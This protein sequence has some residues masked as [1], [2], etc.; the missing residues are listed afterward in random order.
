MAGFGD[1]KDI[2][3]VK[4]SIP[5]TF[6]GFFPKMME[7]KDPRIGSA[8]PGLLEKRP[9]NKSNSSIL[10]HINTLILSVNFWSH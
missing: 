6:K 9:L 8:D 2:Q 7:E 10:F 5:L 3:H 4:K 1:R